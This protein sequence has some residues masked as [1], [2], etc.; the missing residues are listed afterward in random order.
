LLLFIKFY[1]PKWIFAIQKWYLKKRQKISSDLSRRFTKVEKQLNL[2]IARFSGGIQNLYEDL[3][4]HNIESGDGNQCDKI[5]FEALEWALANQNIRNIAITGPYGSGKS[6]ILHHFEKKNTQYN[7]LNISLA[8]F[9]DE[10]FFIDESDTS[11][12]KPNNKW[13]EYLQQIE[14]SI[15][16][17]LAYKEKWKRSNN[18]GFDKIT[19]IRFWGKIR[20]TLIFILGI[21]SF[22][23]AFFPQLFQKFFDFSNNNDLVTENIDLISRISFV[24]FLIFSIGLLYFIIGIY[25]NSRI[26]KVTL[27]D[28]EIELGDKFSNS[29]LN[30]F[31]SEII[32]YFEVSGCNVVFIED[33]DR[34]EYSDTIFEKLR[35]INLLLN[36]AKQLNGR[37]IVFVYATK[38]EV[39]SEKNRTKF[40][41]FIIPI[42]PIIDSKNSEIF[43]R[44]RLEQIDSKLIS[45]ISFYIDDMRLLKNICN[46]FKIFEKR[47]KST[48][49]NPESDSDLKSVFLKDQILALVI[50]K[51]IAPKDFASLYSNPRENLLYNEFFLHRPKYNE[52]VNALIVKK[53]KETENYIE[54]GIDEE[55]QA[56]ELFTLKNQLYKTQ[57]L[58]L[59]ELLDENDILLNLDLS[60][61]SHKLLNTLIKNGF[62]T[63]NY[64][65]YISLFH[66]K[67]DFLTQNDKIFIDSVKQRK[68]LSY[69]ANINNPATVI[70]KLEYELTL[71]KHASVFNYHL[72]E[73]MLKNRVINRSRLSLL[74]RQFPSETPRTN[75]LFYYYNEKGRYQDRFFKGLIKYWPNIWSF[76]IK[77]NKYNEE[78]RNNLLIKLIQFGL[79]K[80]LIV[81]ESELSEYIN[82]HANFIDLIHDIS[83]EN[84]KIIFEKF[85]LKLRHLNESNIGKDL[86]DFVIDQNFYQINSNNLLLLVNHY[87]NRVSEVVPNQIIPNY[88]TILKSQFNPL[89]EYIKEDIEIYIDEVF[90]ELK[91]NDNE[92]I[93]YIEELLNNDLISEEN[94]HIIIETTS[95]ELD[96]FTNIEKI[97]LWSFLFECNRVHPNWENVYNYYFE[98]DNLIDG[99]LVKYLN[100]EINYLELSKKKLSDSTLNKDEQNQI[101]LSLFQC[102]DL[103]DNSYKRIISSLN[104][105]YNNIDL[106]NI[107]K[108]KAQILI[109]CN[110]LSL[111][112]KNVQHLKEKFQLQIALLER[113]KFEIIEK[114]TELN[115]ESDDIIS[116]LKSIIVGDT[117]KLSILPMI[118]NDLYLI[119]SEIAKLAANLILK[120]NKLPSLSISVLCKIIQLG[121]GE[122]NRVRLFNLSIKNYHL[123]DIPQLLESIGGNFAKMNEP[124]AKGWEIANTHE[125]RQLIEFLKTT[126]LL[127]VKTGIMKNGKKIRIYK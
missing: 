69:M 75:E 114:F 104:Y 100:T 95:F 29:L 83:S 125:N 2:K 66:S 113:K 14:Y 10:A 78:K 96:D 9:R 94:K 11:N 85:N 5:A 126:G 26:K 122:S 52:K 43:L 82:N 50:F 42:I 71:F 62:I 34:F 37:R 68:P 57:E 24:V 64:E 74:F 21:Y 127:G 108:T 22:L 6:T 63:E 35:E 1:R 106:A 25:S 23:F 111:T 88:T 40:F 115:L 56:K 49:N 84:R 97:T 32:Y 90:L 72:L 109:E 86:F 121:D 8:T 124:V 54:Q 80:D 13:T 44:N 59:K 31:L 101:L 118:K 33:L 70:E 81:M 112:Q 7:Y 117:I 36:Q 27:K 93:E 45:D 103:H 120:T 99:H 38:D 110:R 58:E 18:S 79:I 28:G 4:P 119:E 123:A 92:E 17:Q 16:Q 51:N 46:E 77:D 76:I 61:I 98:K 47:L 116:V 60:L 41:D 15:L 65:S 30:N 3:T 89:I 48:Y 20:Y 12:V 19:H 55:R 53:I 87:G 102:N 67:D 73:Y 107:S 105:S 91:N 39:F